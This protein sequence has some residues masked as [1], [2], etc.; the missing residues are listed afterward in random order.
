MRAF[1]LC[2]AIMALPAAAVAGETQTYSYDELGRLIAV[3]YSGTVNSGQA[4]SLC[5][6]PAGNRTKYK[7]DAAGALAS[8]TSGGGG[9]GGG[10]GNQPPVATNDT[11]SVVRCEIGYKNVT[12]NDT[13]PEGNT[14]LVVTAVDHATA[15]VDSSTTVGVQAP[16]M[17]G[18]YYV[19]YTVRDSLGATST[20]RLTVTVTGTICP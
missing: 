7:S 9:G 13:D 15:W 12:A 16:D 14:P 2:L 6:D 4:H 5:Y 19:Y 17:S 8:C 10:G 18:S 3:Q 1:A 11:L 20:G